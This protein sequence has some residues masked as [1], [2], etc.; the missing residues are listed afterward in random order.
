MVTFRRTPTQPV[1]DDHH[2]R[3]H[4]PATSFNRHFHTD[5]HVIVSLCFCPNFAEGEPSPNLK[6]FL[7]R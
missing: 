3:E 1:H 7:R 4:S 5:L 2:K 6:F